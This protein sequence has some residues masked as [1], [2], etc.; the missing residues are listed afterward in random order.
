M[1]FLVVKLSEGI[2][3]GLGIIV[4]LAGFASAFLGLQYW[5]QSRNDPEQAKQTLK[6]LIFGVIIFLIL[7][8][9]WNAFG[10]DEVIT[11]IDTKGL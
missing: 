3:T 8:N 7:L 2:S 10:F 9:I 1:F 4:I 6:Y 5:L 11:D